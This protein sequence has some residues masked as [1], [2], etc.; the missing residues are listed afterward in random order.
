MADRVLITGGAGYIG[1][2][3]AGNLLDSGYKVTCLDNFSVGENANTSLLHLVHDPD[4]DFIFGDVREKGLL[5]R[6]VP[7]FDAILPLAAIV[8]APQCEMNRVDAELVNKD[9]VIAINKIRSKNQMLVYP[10][11]NSGYGTTTGEIYCTE[12]TPLNP[13][14]VYGRTKCEAEKALLESGKPVITLRLATAFGASPRM[15]TDLMVHN[16]VLEAVRNKALIIYEGHFKRNFAPVRD[17]ARCFEHCMRNFD[18]MQGKPYNVGLDSANISKLELARKIQE[19]IPDL[20]IYDDGVGKDPDKRNYVVS[21]GR[22]AG[23][24]FKFKHTL[25]EGIDELIKCYK[26]MFG[27]T[28]FRQ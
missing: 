20:R 19:R 18:S 10:T 1:S 13:I 5:E 17:I 4:F 7:Q 8:G 2:V 28:V 12:E 27:G 25:E 16:F 9:S 11:T 21:N 22:L 26:V 6:I 24:G 14:S 23:T 3:L 15:R